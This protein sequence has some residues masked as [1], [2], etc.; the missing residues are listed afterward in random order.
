M[1][2]WLKAFLILLSVWALILALGLAIIHYP[3]LVMSTMLLSLVT[4]ISLVALIAAKDALDERGERKD[5]YEKE[6][7][8]N[9]EKGREWRRRYM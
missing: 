9:A 7:E 8:A 3:K 4:F 6:N 5:D 1:I 2:N